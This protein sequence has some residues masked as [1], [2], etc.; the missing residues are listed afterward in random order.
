MVLSVRGHREA[1][2][3]GSNVKVARDER[4]RGAEKGF[5]VLRDSFTSYPL[6]LISLSHVSLVS[7]SLIYQSISTRAP[8]EGREANS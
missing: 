2:R 8:R 4:V 7:L 1:P 5:P 3:E 6:L